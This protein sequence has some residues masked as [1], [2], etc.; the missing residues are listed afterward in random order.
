MRFLFS[1]GDGALFYDR[2]DRKVY[3]AVYFVAV[4]GF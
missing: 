3:I 4:G 2:C 1:V